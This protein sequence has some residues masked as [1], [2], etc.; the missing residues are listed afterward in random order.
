MP[1]PNSL[2]RRLTTTRVSLSVSSR[3]ALALYLF[4]T[5]SWNPYAPVACPATTASYLTATCRLT[6]L[7]VPQP[8]N[9]WLSRAIPPTDRRTL[10]ESGGIIP[11]PSV[12]AATTTG[13]G[14]A[15]AEL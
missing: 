4:M 8:A 10:T 13:L 2:V 5:R 14:D 11:A 3:A 15:A 1:A 7:S 9:V 12:I 6:A